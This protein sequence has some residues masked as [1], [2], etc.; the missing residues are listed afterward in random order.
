MR[1]LSPPGAGGAGGARLAAARHHDRPSGASARLAAGAPG[2]GHRHGQGALGQRGRLPIRPAVRVAAD[3][4][5]AVGGADDVDG[6]E[7]VHVHVRQGVAF[8]VL[9]RDLHARVALGAPTWPGATATGRRA[10]VLAGHLQLGVQRAGFDG[11]VDLGDLLAV[12][13]VPGL[14]GPGP[15]VQPV[16]QEHRR[17][18]L[19]LPADVALGVAD[20][21]VEVPGGA[22]SRHDHDLRSPGAAAEVLLRDV[23]APRLEQDVGR[24]LPAAEVAARA[25]LGG[26]G[27]D[28]LVQGL[29]VE[30]EPHRVLAA[31]EPDDEDLGVHGPPAGAQRRPDDLHHE[32]THRASRRVDGDAEAAA[33][34]LVVEVP[35]RQVGQLGHHLQAVPGGDHL[36]QHAGG[37]PP[38]ATVGIQGPHGDQLALGQ[39]RSRRHRQP[40][41]DDVTLP[42][43]EQPA[44]LV[45]DLGLER[46]E[47]LQRRLHA[48]DVLP[49][50]GR[51]VGPHVVVGRRAEHG[52]G[53]LG[54]A[55]VDG[56]SDVAQ[57]AWLELE[58]Q[59]VIDRH[60]PRR[61][62]D[63]LGCGT[64]ME[65][66]HHPHL[67][68]RLE[69]D[70]THLLREPVGVDVEH[71][72]AGV[73]GQEPGI[74]CVIGHAALHAQAQPGARLRPVVRAVD[75]DQD[76]RWG[77]R[78]RRRVRSAGPRPDAGR[79]G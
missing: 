53:D 7:E 4:T 33:D 2:Q 65:R 10:G 79:A 70:E 60:S 40:R 47:G 42:H 8:E 64:R 38:R 16:E 6:L 59:R 58:G 68:A 52:E 14:D 11:E 35:D 78:E 27:D 13:G 49:D 71:V 54:G 36:G 69:F 31:A 18:H 72:A 50:Q 61:G 43:G 39:A 44:L 28:L 45:H 41:L 25:H 30:E 76:H 20:D 19:G 21:D 1:R 26:C 66:E 23:V 34:A 77:R 9:D 29:P 74:S 17:R 63:P 32:L 51:G 22:G 67:V 62:V 57:P 48:V 73:D 75:V 56:A 46:A 37:L 3:S 15:G 5:R 24:V 55:L 12:V